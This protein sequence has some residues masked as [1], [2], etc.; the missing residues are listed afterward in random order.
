MD[1]D[2]VINKLWIGSLDAALDTEQLQKNGIKSILSAMRGKLAAIDKVC[3]Q[4]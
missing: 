1:M 3:N 4:V 2:M